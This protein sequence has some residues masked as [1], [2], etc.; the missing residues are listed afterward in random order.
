M[1][2]ELRL[3][4]FFF[5]RAQTTAYIVDKAQYQKGGTKSERYYYGYSLCICKDYDGRYRCP[6]GES[7]MQAL[8]FSRAKNTVPIIEII[9]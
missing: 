4:L 5:F 7:L 2:S 9:A 3:L 8:L 6:R 1:R